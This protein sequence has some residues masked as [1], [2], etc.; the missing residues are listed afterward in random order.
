ME[1]DVNLTIKLIPF[2][3]SFFFF[4]LFPFTLFCFPFSLFPIPFLFFSYSFFF[5]RAINMCD[6]ILVLILFYN[7][8]DQ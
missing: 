2:F 8:S 6:S 4:Y 1:S 3:L 7:L 5:I